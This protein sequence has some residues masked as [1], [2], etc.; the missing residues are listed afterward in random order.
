MSNGL[1]LP[2][3]LFTTGLYQTWDRRPFLVLRS[4]DLECCM[5][6]RTLHGRNN[7]SLYGVV[8]FDHR[9][10]CCVRCS[11]HIHDSS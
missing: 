10:Y 9:I 11:H 2:V 3:I 4:R 7:C 8:E 1:F 5:C 6:H